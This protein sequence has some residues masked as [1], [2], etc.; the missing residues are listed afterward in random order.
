MRQAKDSLYEALERLKPSDRFNII[1]FD[2]GFEPLFDSAKMANQSHMNEAKRFIR[3]IDA[4]GGTEMFKPIDFALKSRDSESSKFLRQIVFITD[5]QSGNEEAIFNNVS[6]NI[7]KD[8]FFTIGIGSA[9]NSYLL[10]K[11]ADFGRGA[12]TYIGSQKEVRQKMNRLFEMLESPALTDIQ[13]NFPP[14]ITSELARDVI[15]DLYAGETITAAFKMNALPDSLEISG[16]TIDGVFNK[17]ITIDKL[18]NTSGVDTLWARRK[19]DRLTDFYNNTYAQSNKDSAR[20]DITNLALD[21]HLISH[22][23]SLVAVD[24]TPS[25]PEYEE[26]ITQAIIKKAKADGLEKEIELNEDGQLQNRDEL[27]L[28][29]MKALPKDRVKD[30]SAQKQFEMVMKSANVPASAFASMKVPDKI[31]ALVDTQVKMIPSS[32]TATYSELLMYIGLS[33]LLIAIILRRRLVL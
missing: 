13:V 9:P 11:L 3:K 31:A 29:L 33:L 5:G 25:R 15:Y 2:S 10:T 24:I 17:T 4:D 12:F 32:Q 21:Y 30:A 18:S 28:A 16:K 20:R 1:D 8:R 14:E 27:M 6:Y 23:T 19:I 22:F 7:R 26:L